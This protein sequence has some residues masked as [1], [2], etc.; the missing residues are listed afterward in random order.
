VA[1]LSRSPGCEKN[2]SRF[3]QRRISTGEEARRCEDRDL[4]EKMEVA[5]TMFINGGHGHA[6]GGDE[7]ISLM[8]F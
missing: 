2:E 8:K 5:F 4:E 1:R 7:I 6:F 3:V